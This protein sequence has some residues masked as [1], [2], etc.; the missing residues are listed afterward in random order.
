[1]YNL[2]EK[3]TVDK[4][5]QGEVLLFNFQK[6]KPNSG[7]LLQE[8]CYHQHYLSFGEWQDSFLSKKVT[9]FIC[10]Y[11]NEICLLPGKTMQG[12]PG[13]IL[14]GPSCHKGTPAKACPITLACRASKAFVARSDEVIPPCI[15]NIVSSTF[16][17]IPCTTCGIN[18]FV[19]YGQLNFQTLIFFF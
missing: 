12:T 13:C 15:K 10:W 6:G 5:L 9:L 14:S 2:D 11:R 1:M 8:H 16:R 3:Q 19:W 17:S 7:P 4:N 18:H